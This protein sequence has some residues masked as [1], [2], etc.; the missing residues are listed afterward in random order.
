MEIVFTFLATDC[1]YARNFFYAIAAAAAIT[2]VIIIIIIISDI[3]E[4]MYVMY[5]CTHKNIIKLFR[6]K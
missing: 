6:L 2:T 4:C 1:I 3:H 5:T